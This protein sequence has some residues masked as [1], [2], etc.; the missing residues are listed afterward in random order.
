MATVSASH[1]PHI[2]DTDDKGIALSLFE[3]FS[4]SKKICTFQLFS[5]GSASSKEPGT[6]GQEAAGAFGGLWGPLSWPEEPKS[7]L[8]PRH[9]S[10]SS[11]WSPASLL[12]PGCF[13]VF[14]AHSSGLEHRVLI[15]Q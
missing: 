5:A 10:R 6:R 1:L 4:I 7:F 9:G 8:Q 13:L 14:M 15:S 12:D 11:L 3:G 2:K